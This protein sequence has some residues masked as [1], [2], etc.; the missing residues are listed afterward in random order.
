MAGLLSYVNWAYFLAITVVF[1]IFV[2]QRGFYIRLSGGI[3][4]ICMVS[5]ALLGIFAYFSIDW[6]SYEE[7]VTRQFETSGKAASNFEPFW[8]WVSIVVKG[9]IYLFRSFVYVPCYIILFLYL[10]FFIPSRDR[11][12]VFFLYIIF[13]LYRLDGGRQGLSIMLFY[14]AFMLLQGNLFQKIT[15]IGFLICSVFLHK[16]SVIFFPL[17]IMHNINLSRKMVM[18]SLVMAGLAFIWFFLY[19][20]GFMQRFFPELIYVYYW[21]EEDLSEVSRRIIYMNKIMDIVNPLFVFIILIKAF[22]CN[23]SARGIKYRNFLYYGFLLYFFI[24]FTGLFNSSIANRY[25]GLMLWWPIIL[26]TA[27]VL[28]KRPPRSFLFTGFFWAYIA[29]FFVNTNIQISGR[30]GI[31]VGLFG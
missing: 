19:F 2:L 20:K 22:K 29:L 11:F 17:L 18:I 8:R 23:L 9:N 6:P 1:F 12:F 30:I 10:F 16:G 24:R 3:S 25:L 13:M 14:F 7:I 26:L 28:R 21:G 27:E 15:A 31:V 4:F 5:F